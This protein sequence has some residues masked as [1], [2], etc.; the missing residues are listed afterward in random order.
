MTDAEIKNVCEVLK[1]LNL[2]TDEKLQS[3]YP[4]VYPKPIVSTA[5]YRTITKY[6]CLI[7]IYETS[8]NETVGMSLGVPNKLE[9][10][11][12]IDNLYKIETCKINCGFFNFDG[13]A[14]HLGLLVN[15][16]GLIRY[17]DNSFINYL[18]FKEDGHTEICYYSGNPEEYLWWDNVLYWGIGVGYSLVNNGVINLA[19]AEKFSHST[20]DNPRTMMGQLKN[21]NFIL[22][23]ADGRSTSSI[24]LT[25]KEEADIMLSLGCVTAV[26]LDGGG[27]SEMIVNGKIVSKPSDGFERKIGSAIM[28]YKK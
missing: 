11:S 26:N 12:A 25:A 18:Y 24:G 14:E 3:V 19:N 2:V 10:L 23:V 8:I 28:V 21:G 9:P 7:H 15:E 5:G 1:K 13:S 16:N 27:S 22:A 17:P 4:T 20:S 6:N